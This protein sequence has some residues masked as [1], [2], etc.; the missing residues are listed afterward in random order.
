MMRAIVCAFAFACW[1]PTMTVAAEREAYLGTAS[2]AASTCHGGVIDRGPSWNHSF[3]TWLANDPHAGAGLL[4]RDDD[5]RQIVERL[6][7]SAAESVEAYDTLLRRRCISCH[8]TVSADQCRQSGPLEDLLLSRGVDCESCH[9]PAKSWLEDH[10]RVGWDRSAAG[11]KMSDTKSIIGRA[12]TCVPCHVGSRSSDGMVRDMN[13]DLIAAGHPA[14]RFDLLIYNENLPKH[15][16]DEA[17]AG[18]SESALKVR[19]VGRAVNLATSATLA[20]ERARDH[21]DDDSVPWP[22]LADY[23]CFGCHQSLSMEEYRL[24]A[25]RKR[26]G[27]SSLRVSDGLPIWNPWHSLGQLE[28]SRE[29]LRMLAPNRADAKAVAEQA[30]RLASLYRER[31]QLHQRDPVDVQA[32]LRRYE[33]SLR[34]TPPRDWHQAAIHYLQLEAVLR[35]LTKRRE[36]PLLSDPDSDEGM[37]GELEQLLRFNQPGGQNAARR[38]DSPSEFNSKRFQQIALE[39]LETLP[40]QDGNDPPAQLDEQ[41]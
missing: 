21:L 34:K 23:D 9:G 31:A 19:R 25:A 40:N 14:L 12:T 22:E 37:I 26:Q 3:S 4:L 13:H 15:W 16:G 5:S 33:D 41:P 10:T 6:E 11:S 28:I 27:R 39:L 17:E 30:P 20:A 29:Q 2:C 36:R 35:D 1:F 8:V 24:P 32:A 18:F 7:P 38:F